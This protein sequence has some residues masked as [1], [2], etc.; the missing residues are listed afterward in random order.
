MNLTVD[1]WVFDGLVFEI[2]PQNFNA[3]F[4]KHEKLHVIF[5]AGASNVLVGA[6]VATNFDDALIGVYVSGQFQGGGSVGEPHG[7]FEN[8]KQPFHGLKGECH[9]I[10]MGLQEY[11]C[12][13]G[14][15]QRVVG[16][17]FVHGVHFV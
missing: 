1:T 4:L 8:L 15:I 6:V 3:G 12:D 7:D 13:F 2:L 14:S 5:S 10:F 9:Q 17:F 11:F 16:T